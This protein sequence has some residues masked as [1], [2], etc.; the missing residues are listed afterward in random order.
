VSYLAVPEM[1]IDIDGDGETDYNCSE[2]G[3]VLIVSTPTRSVS[4]LGKITRE[5][6]HCAVWEGEGAVQRLRLHSGVDRRQR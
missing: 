3:H 6:S 1:E 5:I 4:H 2:S